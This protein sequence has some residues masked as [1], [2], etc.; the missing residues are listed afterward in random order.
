VAGSLCRLVTAVEAKVAERNKRGWLKLLLRVVVGVGVFAILIARTNLRE[1]GHEVAGVRVGFILGAV[2]LFFAGLGISTLRWR[3]Y[4]VA[5]D[6]HLP[7]PTLFRLYF[8]GTFFNAFLPTGVGGD[9]YKAV[10]LG[11][12]Y[13]R[14]PT[15]FSSVFLDRFSG[16]IGVALIGLTGGLIRIAQGDRSWVPVVAALAAAGILVLAAILLGFGTKLLGR[17]RLVP[18]TGWGAKVRELV[19]GIHQAGRHPRAAAAGFALG[20]GFQAMV[21]GYHLLLARALGLSVPA[22][23]MAC[24]VILISTAVLV[25]ISLSGLGIVETVYVSALTR[26]SHVFATSMTANQR[27]AK[28]LAFALVVRAIMLLGSAVGGILYLIVGGDVKA[29]RAI[30]SAAL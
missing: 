22:A 3:E 9:A 6:F 16:I 25:P 2:A 23:L 10:R 14:T 28:A 21:L 12:A 24:V 20:T 19:A 4:L 1:L 17:G 11:K 26:Y 18:H 7:Y 5:L 15:L 30:E 27:H 13:G 29:R 8:V